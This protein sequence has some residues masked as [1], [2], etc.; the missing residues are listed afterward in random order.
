MEQ[1]EENNFVCVS[2]TVEAEAI[3][4]HSLYAEA[5]FTFPLAIDRLSGA[6][7]IL[8]ITAGERL[9]ANLPSP[10][11]ALTIRGQLRSY[12]K[13]TA[14]GSRLLVTVF[15]R[16]VVTHEE[17]TNYQNEI[18]LTGFV[19]KPPVYRTTPFMREITDILLAVNR[20]YHKSDY[21]PVITWGRN[22]RFAAELVVG[23]CVRITGRVQSREYQ[24]LLPSG[25]TISKTTYE[26]SA[27]RIE[28][29]NQ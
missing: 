15:A 12:N 23:D 25:E 28:R 16:S 8:P 19:C 22:A 7:D 17:C 20:S 11:D 6:Q 2:G 26:V 9:L 10:G 14:Q 1:H 27:N 18:V 13:Q 21:L 4:S 24:K 3:F 29:S 5:F